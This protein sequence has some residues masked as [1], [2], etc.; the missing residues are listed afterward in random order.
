MFETWDDA[1]WHYWLTHS[2]EEAE[3]LAD[4]AEEEGRVKWPRMKTAS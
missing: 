2:V 4:W 1:F 3:K